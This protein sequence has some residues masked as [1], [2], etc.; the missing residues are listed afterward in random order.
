MQMNK[1]E[2]MEKKVTVP[3]AVLLLAAIV[4][5][6]V[7]F[8]RC[9][10]N[11]TVAMGLTWVIFYLASVILRMDWSKVWQ[12]GMDVIH[13]G[14]AA[15]AIVLA[16][17]MLI[18]SWIACGTIP[19]II[20]LGLEIINPKFFLPCTLIICSLMSL[21]T[22]T[23]GGSVASAGVA[24]IGVGTAMGVSIPATAGAIICGAMF[25]DKISPLSDTTNM[26]PALTGTTLGRHIK[27][28]MFT[29]VVPYVL[30]L[31]FF[32]IYGL[33]YGSSNGD[34]RDISATIQT[35]NES[36]NLSPL[37]L[38]PLVV[39][40]VL[41]LIKVDVA[42]AI[43]LAAVFAAVL[44]PILQGTDFMATTIIMY[45]GYSIDTGNLIVDKLLNRGGIVSMQG[46]ACNT[47]FALGMGGMLEYVGVL[48]A[49][50]KPI[51]NKINSMPKLIG[52]T[53]IISYMAA[54]MTTTMTSGNTITGRLMAPVFREKGVAPEVCSRTL[55]DCGTLAGPL[56][57]WHSNSFQYAAALG[58]A[59]PACWIPFLPLSYLT[60]IMSLVCAFTGFGI[61][62]IN[63]DGAYCSKQEHDKEYPD[64]F[65]K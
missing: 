42:P 15:I 40:I 12:A 44:A 38:L 14:F 61:W 43:M 54:G 27:S 48:H 37:C 52:L 7:L 63:K 49:L 16:V 22:G 24:L 58:I 45:N 50:T 29:T 64:A 9:G 35:L 33:Q 46:P 5:E 1:T 59:N 20:T 26:C 30:S 39:I 34:I 62:Y 3:Q 65:K 8:V 2:S 4:G 51:M 47:I 31:V 55:E 41:L 53:M 10:G 56:M 25:G 28:M 6:I 36:F 13:G 21:F 18:G 23:S 11:F 32:T 17:G 60:P 19:Y 57:P